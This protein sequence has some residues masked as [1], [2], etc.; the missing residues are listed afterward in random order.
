MDLRLLKLL[1]VGERTQFLPVFALVVPR[2]G[3]F[4]LSGLHVPRFREIEKRPQH[5][6]RRLTFAAFVFR[7]RMLR[8]ESGLS[9]HES[10]LRHSTC[11]VKLPNATSL[12]I[13]NR[14]FL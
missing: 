6:Y 8:D 10:L 11:H 13:V 7:N 1:V 9:V 2:T 5:L 14:L 4:F 12:Y 3:S